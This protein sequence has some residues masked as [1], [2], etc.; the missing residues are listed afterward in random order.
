MLT[1]G[2]DLGTTNVKGIVFNREGEKVASV[3]RP[4]RTH[5]RGTEIAD[6]YPE[7]FWDEIQAVLRELVSLC[8]HPEEIRALSFASF[9]ETGVALDGKGEPLAPCIAWFDHRSREVVDEW[10]KGIDEYEVFR[11]TGMRVSHIPSLAKILWEKKHLPEVYRKTKKWLFL[12][13]YIILRLTGE[14]KTDHSMA[15]RSLLFDVRR[16]VWSE[17]MCELADIPMGILP[18]AVPSGTPVGEMRKGVAS[19]LG[20]RP[21]VIVVLGGHD[22]LCGSFSAGLRRK[23]E[24][25]NSSGTGDALCA[26]I[27]PEQVDERFFKA[28]V[29]YGCHV[30]GGH[31]YLLGGTHTAG[32][33]ID[34]FIDTFYA[35]SGLARG[36]IYELMIERASRSPVG[37]NGV[38]VLP[39][40]RG[41][42][43]PYNDPVS[44]GAILGLRS[45]H[46]L[47]DIA[48]AL[49]EGLSLELRGVVDKFSELTGDPYSEMKYIGGGSR[50]HFWIQMKADVLE[51]KICVN[52]IQENTSHGAALLAGIGSGVY[53]DADEAFRAVKSAEET[54]LPNPENSQIY[55]QMYEGVYRNLYGKMIGLNQDIESLLRSL[56]AR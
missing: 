21:G 43:T 4:T 52:T 24:L 12:V 44:K 54:F 35:D 22:H 49:F 41:C 16:K 20:L 53:R 45:T 55:R 33:L 26:L 51:R 34:W 9:G 18:P 46:T 11:I 6:F 5:Y 23:G 42:L 10:R 3:T 15:S 30:A 39:H 7:E 28:G 38:V 1:I 40:L 27:D 14:Y 19:S 56:P 37:S 25:L 17:R 48:R 32:R 29:S 2:I 47:N 13:S 36:R 50:N 8:P 31:T